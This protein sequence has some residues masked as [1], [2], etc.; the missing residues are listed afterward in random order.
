M[1]ESSL[2]LLLSK[3]AKNQIKI[4]KL[5]LLLVV[6]VVLLLLLLLLLLRDTILIG[7]LHLQEAGQKSE[8]L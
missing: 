3:K 8:E 1:C 7:I 2:F 6:V 5:L 4:Q